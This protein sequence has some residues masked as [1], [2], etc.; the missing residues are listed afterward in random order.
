LLK[1]F[2]KSWQAQIKNGSN[3]ERHLE[4]NLVLLQ[5]KFFPAK[6]LFCILE[7]GILAGKTLLIKIVNLLCKEGFFL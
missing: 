4:I 5:S 1:D 2:Y 6:F 3:P 7:K